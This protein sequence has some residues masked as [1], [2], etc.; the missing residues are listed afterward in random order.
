[1]KITGIAPRT[2]SKYYR[3]I[4]DSVEVNVNLSRKE[5]KYLGEKAGFASVFPRWWLGAKPLY[6][7][8]VLGTV[9]YFRG[10]NGAARCTVTPAL[11]CVGIGMRMVF[12][13][14]PAALRDIRKR[15]EIIKET[16]KR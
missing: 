11:T 12:E 5:N 6:R 7:P 10:P 16:G 14:S 2:E 1:M 13:Y 15:W 9:I 4:S 3:E 8:T